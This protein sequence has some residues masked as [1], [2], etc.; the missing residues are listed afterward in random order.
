MI[1][2]DDD[3]PTVA[4]N[5]IAMTLLGIHKLAPMRAVVLHYLDLIVGRTDL[6]DCL[7]Y[8]N[9]HGSAATDSNNA[10][11]WRLRDRENGATRART[12]GLEHFGQTNLFRHVVG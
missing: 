10:Y 3:D 11:L 4:H 6:D 5:E 8:A 1:V 2:A 9:S 7:S 12:T